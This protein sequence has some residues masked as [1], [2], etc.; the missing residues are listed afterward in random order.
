[1]SNFLGDAIQL[2]RR[3]LRSVSLERDARS[4]LGLEGYIPTP[5]AVS[6]KSRIESALENPFLRAVNIT[7]S[8]GTGKSAFAL[9]LANQLAS[10]PSHAKSRGLLPV[11]ITG[12]RE[13][14]IPALMRGLD[15]SVYGQVSLENQNLTAKEAAE[16]FLQAAQDCRR[17]NKK[18]QGLLVIVDELGKFL[19][20]AAQ[21]PERSDLHVL[22][23]IAEIA[24]RSGDAPVVFVTILHQAFDEYAH[25]LS[26]VQRAEWQKIQ[27]R[28]IDIPFGDNAEEVVRLIGCVFESEKSAVDFAITRAKIHAEQALSLRIMPRGL[29]NTQDT[30][31]IFT[32]AFA[33]HPLT[34]LAL[35]HLFKR[36]AQSERTLFAFLGAD[37]P[38][39]FGAYIAEQPLTLQYRVDALFD[40]VTAAL[41]TALYSMP[42]YSKLWS[43]IQ[44][45]VARCENRGNALETRVVKT[46]GLLH[47]L[48]ESSRLSPSPEVVRFALVDE[49]TS[50]S[51]VDAAL[52]RL[53]QETILNFRTFRNVYRPYE[54]SDIDVE[55]RLREARSALGNGV[56]LTAVAAKRLPLSP[57]IARGHSFKTGTLRFFEVSLCTPAD[58]AKRINAEPAGADASLL[59][60]L[61]SDTVEQAETVARAIQLSIPARDRLHIVVAICNISDALRDAAFNVEALEWVRENTQ[62]LADD[63]VAHREIME[64]RNEAIQE[65]EFQWGCLLNTESGVIFV[66]QG[67]TR[68][69]A[70]EGYA[71]QQFL[72]EV[73]Q[74]AYYQSPL[75]RNELLNRRQ[76]SSAA[77]AARRNLIEAMILN[78]HLPALGIDGFPAE[79]MMYETVLAASG[80]HGMREGAGEWAFSDSPKARDPLRISSA[81]REFEHFLLAG[82][83]TQKPI[84][85]LYKRLQQRPFGIADGV[86]PVLLTAAL[87]CW[88]DEILLYE[89]GVLITQLDPPVAERLLRR[90]QDYTVQGLRIA[91]ERQSV[92]IRFGKGLL[93]PTE[94]RTIVNVVRAI[95]AQVNKLPVY[96]RSTQ[97][98][99]ATAKR[100]REALKEA[101]NPDNLLFMELPKIF[102]VKPFTAEQ[103]TENV[104]AFFAAWNRTFIELIGGYDALLGR[105]RDNLLSAFE[106]ET[107]EDIRARAAALVGRVS[108]PKLVAFVRRLADK[109]VSGPSWIESVASGVVGR[110]PET[111]TDADEARFVNA[112]P[113]LLSGFR[114]T[115]LVA[116]AMTEAQ[117][118]SGAEERVAM[119]VSVAAP[120]GQEDARVI[121]LPRHRAHKAE[122]SAEKLKKSMRRIFEGQPLEDRVAALGYLLREMLKDTEKEK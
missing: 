64:R 105:L 119:R 3:F 91:G 28:F 52:K 106:T 40:Y 23:E 93:K 48:G 39:G 118:D 21:Y 31:T 115:E 89:N 100:L 71:L 33:L 102:G 35:P 77:A 85:D 92:L 4:G 11:L 47:L 97:S 59:L 5:T 75:L 104:D 87:L 76:L 44:E 122:E 30:E 73:L 61:T 32:S 24:T 67:G 69:L 53:T 43:Q 98:L 20:F 8:Y 1:M 41:S 108:E 36:F 110:S 58:M 86:L 101:R 56:S 113:G 15:A 46:V 34:I 72:S 17:K 81:W 83:L 10:P 114:S 74:E 51:D 65:L 107:P 42:S 9:Y 55:E 49:I 50:Q 22:Q 29:E 62:G 13:S 38:Q 25:R 45:S 14:L 19:E 84:T 37:D 27:G 70:G 99:G 26:A 111:W 78:R 96:T 90:P 63:P 2:K 112:L 117:E 54:G 57:I 79:R 103:D 80:L 18:C 6:V 109:G 68:S 82:D 66:W 12:G 94:K 16:R 88:E 60:C 121:I 95:Y 116:F 7:G 120:G